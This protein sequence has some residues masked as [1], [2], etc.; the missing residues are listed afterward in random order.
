MGVDACGGGSEGDFASAQVI[1]ES[2]MQCAELMARLTPQELAR[3]VERLAWKYGNVL[4]VVERNGHGLEVLAY[5]KHTDVTLYED[6]KE[7]LGFETNQKTRPEVIAKLVEFASEHMEAFQSRRLLQQMRTFIR[8][9]NGRA[10]AATGEYDDT[11]M[12]MGIALYVREQMAQHQR[13]KR[14]Q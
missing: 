13:R 14:Q 2:G 9:Y 10:E 1:D 11:V 3:E 6:E 12:A 5:L 7:T 4:V 8:K